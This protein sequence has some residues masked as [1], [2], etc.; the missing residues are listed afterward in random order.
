MIHTWLKHTDFTS[1]EGFNETY[2]SEYFADMKVYGQ[3][4]S[5][6][7]CALTNLSRSEIETGQHFVDQVAATTLRL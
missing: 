7:K 3:C 5:R 1:L 2:A 6:A 4:Q